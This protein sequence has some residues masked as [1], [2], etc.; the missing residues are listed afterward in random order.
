MK[1]LSFI[2]KKKD[3]FQF[4]SEQSPLILIKIVKSFIGTNYIHKHQYYLFIYNQIVAITGSFF[5]FSFF[6]L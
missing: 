4:I 5:P 3:F 6:K 1:F 2:S